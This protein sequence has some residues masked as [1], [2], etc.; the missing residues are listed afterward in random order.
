[1]AQVDSIVAGRQADVRKRS[2]R[3]SVSA[4]AKIE[5]IDGT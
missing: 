1:M 4:D 3:V 5:T 2:L